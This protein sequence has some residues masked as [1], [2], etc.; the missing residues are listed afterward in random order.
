[1]GHFRLY[2]LARANPIRTVRAT[3]IL[4]STQFNAGDLRALRTARASVKR[5]S[6]NKAQEDNFK[7]RSCHDK[8]A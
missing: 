6:S 3:S 8:G 7:P 4:K 5:T 1:M 2:M